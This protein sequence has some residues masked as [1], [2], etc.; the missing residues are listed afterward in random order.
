VLWGFFPIYW[1]FLSGI[2]VLQLTCHRIVWSCAVLFVLIARSNG[3][4][5][6]WAAIKSVRVIGIYAAA[7]I[8]IGLNWLIFVWAVDQGHI[9]QTSLGYFV[10]PLLSVVLGV[11]VFRERLRWLQW[12]S[13]GL[14]AAGVLYLT[15]ALGSPPWIALALAGSFGTYGLM[16]K[17][18]PLSA[19]Q[20]LALETAILCP[21]AAAYLIAAEVS[22]AGAFLHSGSIRDLLM[23][24]S[25]PVTTIPLLLFA[26]GARRIPLSLVGML[27][28]ISPALQFLLATLVFDEPFDR[29][30][31]IGFGLVWAA[32]ALFAVEGYRMHRWPQLGVTDIS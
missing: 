2:S 20:G 7:S 19:V 1:K 13:V 5:A 28:Y 25:G 10:S 15:I 24:G 12:V 32:L 9:V 30:Q 4:R 8:T 26:A 18:A 16:K 31:A 27:Q 22:G 29:A 17:I 23:F 11:L 14:A 6:L 21:P 3:W